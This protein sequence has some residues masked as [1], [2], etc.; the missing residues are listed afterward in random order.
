TGDAELHVT[1][2]NN[3]VTGVDSTAFGSAG[4]YF[5]S[6]TGTDQAKLFSNVHAGSGAGGN[7]ARG[8][9]A[10][11]DNGFDLRQRAGATF[12]LTGLATSGTSDANVESF[13][14]ANNTGDADVAAAGGTTI[15]NYA[16]GATQL[17]TA[18]SMPLLAATPTAEPSSL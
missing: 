11:V 3:E 18:P 5:E 4:F 10:A 6:G 8:V 1:L 12:A 2:Q 9:I 17:P 16:S 13:I 14:Q 7:S 15:V